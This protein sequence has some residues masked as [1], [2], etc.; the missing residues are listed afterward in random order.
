MKKLQACTEPEKSSK[1]SCEE[2]AD[3]LAKSTGQ[4]KQAHL[5]RC[6]THKHIRSQF[7]FTCLQTSRGASYEGSIT[8]IIT[9]TQ[10]PC[11]ERAASQLRTKPPCR[12]ISSLS[13]AAAATAAAAAAANTHFHA[14][15]SPLLHLGDCVR[16][17]VGV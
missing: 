5:L 17:T 11:E 16:R 1:S 7:P 12:C 14:L 6:C 10:H 2:A 9:I 13:S 8:L 15:G 4:I 3:L